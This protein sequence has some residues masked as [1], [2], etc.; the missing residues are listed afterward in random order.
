MGRGPG[1]CFVPVRPFGSTPVERN[2]RLLIVDAIGGSVL[3]AAIAFNA[4]Y[5]VRLG[6]T[7]AEVGLLASLPSLLAVVLTLPIGGYLE[8]LRSLVPFAWRALSLHRCG[9]LLLV[10]VPMVPPEAR[11]V[12]LVGLL[13]LASAP[14]T[15]FGVTLNTLF[16]DLLPDQRRSGVLSWRMIALSIGALV[17]TPLAGYWLDRAEF[18]SNYM[19]LYLVATAWAS[20]SVLAIRGLRYP[21]EPPRRQPVA[22]ALLKRPL[23]T[24]RSFSGETGFWRIVLDTFVHGMGAWL[25]TPLYVLLYVRE[26]GATDGWFGLLTAVSAGAQAIGYYLWQRGVTR[27]GDR[28]VLIATVTVSGFFP[29]VVGLA[30]SLE[31]V[32]A[33]T[34]INGLVVPGLGLS[35][36]PTFIRVCPADRRPT[37]ISLYT[38]LMNVGAFVAP[39]LSVA[40]I[41]VI[42]VRAMLVIAGALWA[43]SG[44]LFWRLPPEPERRPEAGAPA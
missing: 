25:A 43:S 41:E 21:G 13:V 7:N 33:L 9:Y 4:V 31:F 44:L 3:N 20:M 12:L 1:A 16:G 10:L 18:P 15:A 27:W 24:L 40:A 22:A 42:G 19:V 17:V 32:I 5:A 37:F 2:S 23:A 28:R 29:L 39:L 36:F 11:P 38:V 6:A 14:L 34:V 8:T 35:H 30:P 26:M